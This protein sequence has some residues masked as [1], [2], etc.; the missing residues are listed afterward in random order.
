MAAGDSALA[1][2][3]R[4]KSHARDLVEKAGQYL[5]AVES[6]MTIASHLKELKQ[7]GWRILEDR[8]WPRS[9]RANVDFLAVGPPGVFII[10]AKQWAEV[11][12]ENGVLFRGQSDESTALERQR[13][14]IDRIVSDLESSGLV[15]SA[16]QSVFAFTNNAMTP[17][18]LGP[19][20]LMGASS[21]IAWLISQPGRLPPDKITEIADALELTCPPVTVPTDRAKPWIARKKSV[22][23]GPRPKDQPADAPLI[24]ADE[25][26]GALSAALLA[27][28]IEDWMTFVHPDQLR[29]V[30]T[31]WNGPYRIRGP[32]GTGK[33]VVGLHRAVYLAQRSDLPILFSSFV[34]TLPRVQR[35]LARRISEPAAANIEFVHIHLL[36]KRILEQAAIPI[37]L[38][39]AKVRR[40]FETAW[41]QTGAARHLARFEAR[42]DYWLEEIDYVIK[43]RGILDFEDYHDLVRVGR[44]AALPRDVR[45]HVWD[46]YV[47]YGEILAET[48]VC[49]F[50]DLLLNALDVVR[51]DPAAQRYGAVIVDEVQDLTLTGLKLLRA[52]ARDDQ[53]LLIGDGQQSIYPGGYNLAEA[54][55]NVTGRSSILR[56]NYRNTAEILERAIREVER[57]SFDDLDGEPASGGRDTEVLRH[58]SHP[59]TVFAASRADLERQLVDQVRRSRD[60]G[61][62]L[63]DMAVLVSN[64]DDVAR[65]ARALNTAAL[66]TIDL[67]DYDGVTQD[68][69]KVGTLKRAKGLDFKFVLMPGLRQAPPARK[70]EETE[71][72]YSERLVRHHRETFV[73][74]TRARDG[75]WLGYLP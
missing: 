8:E 23:M 68:R 41:V 56:V 53:M 72:A 40:A 18:C 58:G 15:P 54:G 51:E 24:D 47:R 14:L 71:D 13:E 74:M 31:R 69:I 46:L 16:I 59:L 45:P 33:T 39:P 75:L 55:I 6:E 52:V 7:L 28:P 62:P 10:D 2:A 27:K 25:I 34:K 66:P 44:K 49:D 20:T 63:G 11:S 60:F 26:H 30:G 1:H 29:L 35:S 17:T 67:L 9:R 22:A 5:I 73:G 57:D 65:Y 48:E 3:Q 70:P 43:G 38:N 50:N 64:R 4:L 32:A 37:D 36:A 61:I 19:V 21:L 42:P 12:I